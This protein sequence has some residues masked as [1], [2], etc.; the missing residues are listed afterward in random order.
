MHLQ[1]LDDGRLSL[2][3][4]GET[5]TI[6]AGQMRI[7][8]S[9]TDLRPEIMFSPDSKLPSS[10]FIGDEAESDGDNALYFRSWQPLRTDTTIVIYTEEVRH[11]ARIVIEAN[12]PADDSNSPF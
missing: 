4:E 3:E 9:S 6:L 2:V 8:L 5:V 12:N 1:V 7:R 10:F 11:E